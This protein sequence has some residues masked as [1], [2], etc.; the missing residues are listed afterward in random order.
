MA[1]LNIEIPRGL[2]SIVNVVTQFLATGNDSGPAASSSYWE[3]LRAPATRLGLMYM[4]QAVLTLIYIQSLSCVGERMACQLRQD[5]FASIIRQD[6]SFYDQHRTGE[7]VN[8]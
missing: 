7:L 5:L 3:E 4:G 2:G 8:R 1:V 6:V